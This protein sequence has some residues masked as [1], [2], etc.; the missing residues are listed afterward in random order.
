MK[1]I[2]K[3]TIIKYII[4]TLIVLTK[5]Q[6]TIKETN[7]VKNNTTN[8]TSARPLDVNS[9]NSTIKY[10]NTKSYSFKKKNFRFLKR[11][12]IKDMAKLPK[13]VYYKVYISKTH[14]KI[15]RVDEYRHDKLNRTVYYKYDNMRKPILAESYLPDGKL[16]YVS[17]YNK[18]HVLLSNLQYDQSGNVLFITR[19]KFLKKG[20]A[21]YWFNR[22][23]ELVLLIYYNKK[24]QPVRYAYYKSGKLNA[25]VDYLYDKKGFLRRQRHYSSR[26]KEKKYV[27]YQYASNGNIRHSK[28]YTRGTL[29]ALTEY[30]KKGR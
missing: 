6:A 25:V 9:K 17:R 19:I 11:H 12:S 28:T 8:N 3:I 24:F 30:D 20:L 18:K 23:R 21:E 4:I 10:F 1:V 26:M 2:N 22:G 16:E 7:P 5:C 27:D 29:S 14:K 15:A 13:S